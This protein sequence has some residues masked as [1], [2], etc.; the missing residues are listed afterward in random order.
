MISSCFAE[1]NENFKAWIDEFIILENDEMKLLQLLKRFFK[2]YRAQNLAVFSF[3]KS[4]FF[5][6]KA[7]W[8]CRIIDA[9]SVTF[10]PANLSDLKNAIN[11]RIAA[12]FWEYVHGVSWICTS[13]T[14]FSELVGIL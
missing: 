2:I 1:L 8:C 10:N 7:E 3:P 9:E 11:P 6:K 14:R 13:I 12:E 4:N 5:L